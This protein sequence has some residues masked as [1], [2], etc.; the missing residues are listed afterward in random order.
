M[1]FFL[2]KE[3]IE[4]IRELSISEYQQIIVNLTVLTESN[5]L[6]K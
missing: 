4:K 1:N 6:L 2:Q 3:D 5:R